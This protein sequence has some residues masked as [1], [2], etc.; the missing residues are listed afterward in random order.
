MLIP[1]AGAD[2]RFVP[3]E[4]ILQGKTVLVQSRSVTNPMYVR[5]GWSS[6]LENS[7]YNSDGLPASTFTSEPSPLR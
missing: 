1:D 3:A 4:A 2:H 5:F 6:F 7:L